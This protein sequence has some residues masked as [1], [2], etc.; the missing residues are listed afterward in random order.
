L[1]KL[2]GNN[3]SLADINSTPANK[4][5]R[6]KTAMCFNSDVKT[7]FDSRQEELGSKDYLRMQKS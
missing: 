6:T 2:N 1:N 3:L 4:H 5:S 7:T